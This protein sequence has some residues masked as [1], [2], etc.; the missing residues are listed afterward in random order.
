MKTLLHIDEAERVKLDEERAKRDA[1]LEKWHLVAIEG[2]LAGYQAGCIPLKR[3]LRG[4]RASVEVLP[5]DIGWAVPGGTERL[6]GHVVLRALDGPSPPPRDPKGGRGGRLQARPDAFK[7][8]ARE[9]VALIAKREKLAVS[10]EPAGGRT[11][12][13][14]RA[15]EVYRAAGVEGVTPAIVQGWYEKTKSFTG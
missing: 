10:R 4:V 13:F 11:S 8:A 9:L 15:A 6:L 7:N 1:A 14:D 12:A 2:W 5:D 3:L